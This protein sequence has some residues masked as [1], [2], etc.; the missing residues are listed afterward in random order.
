MVGQTL[1]GFRLL[2]LPR[3]QALANNFEPHLLIGRK[4]QGGR[5]PFPYPGSQ[6]YTLSHHTALTLVHQH[7]AHPITDEDEDVLVGRLLHEAAQEFNI[8]ELSNPVAFDF[9]VSVKDQI[10]WSHDVAGLWNLNPH[11][12]KTDEVFLDVARRMLEWHP[13]GRWCGGGLTG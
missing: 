5:R 1:D 9:D 7:L 12:L 8:S 4:L 2:P 6:F 3:R 13:P 10:A 11:R